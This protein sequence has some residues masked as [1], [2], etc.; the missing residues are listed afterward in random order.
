[1]KKKNKIKIQT[2]TTSDFNTSTLIKIIIGVVLV[3]ILTYFIGGLLNGS[4]KIGG[5]EKKEKEE[6]V[7][8]YSEIIIGETFTQKENEYYVLYYDFNSDLNN[9]I[10]SYTYSYM[11]KQDALKMYTVDLSDGFNKDK[12]AEEN[13]NY[14][15]KPSNINDLKVQNPT[16]LK[17]SNKKVTERI[18]GKENTIN[19]LSNLI[20]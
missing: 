20:K 17:I 13:E 16:I 10:E 6:T 11:Y 3:L 8:Q 5:K 4:I 19:Y 2:S 18:E 14:I 9:I 12:V 1:M 15:N 7:I